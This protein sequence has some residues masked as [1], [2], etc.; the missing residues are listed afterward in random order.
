M[1]NQERILL[2]VNPVAGGTDKTEL[3][4]IVS[5]GVGAWG[6]SLEVYETSCDYNNEQKIR[7]LVRDIN[8]ERVLVAGGDGTIQLVAGILMDT[9]TPMGVLPAG[10][11][12]G[13]AVSLDIPPTIE[14]QLAIALGN[15]VVDIDIL[16]IDNHI[17]IHL[18]DLGVNAELVK[19]YEQG[20][21]RGKLGYVLQ[22]IP[23]LISADFPYTFDIEANGQHYTWTG[24]L[25]VIA[26]AD[27]FGTGA[28][29]NPTGKINDGKFEVIV[30]KNFDVPAI[31]KTLNGQ[32]TPDMDFVDIISTDHAVIT[33]TDDVPFQVDGEFI[34]NRRKTVAKVAKNKV[35]L[36]L[37]PSAAM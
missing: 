17:C 34:G 5:A 11:A 16:E 32:L 24:I 20:N 33:T 25:L 23:S 21:I 35:K 7:D 36:A 22:S 13:F 37:P 1:N 26:N 10:S 19:N 29:I 31:I 27:K 8:P 18:A 6:A 28:I 3:I 30:F 2:V 4:N 12:N 9:E 15:N 14:E